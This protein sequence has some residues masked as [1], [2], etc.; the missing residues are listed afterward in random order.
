M[1]V[2]VFLL[3][4]ILNDIFIACFLKDIQKVYVGNEKQTILMIINLQL[5]YMYNL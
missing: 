5:F 1:I 3:I 4:T 2:P